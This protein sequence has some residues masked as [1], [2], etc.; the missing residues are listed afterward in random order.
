M[1]YKCIPM[2]EKC[3][4]SSSMKEDM[5]KCIVDPKKKFPWHV[6]FH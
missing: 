1:T 5:P 3:F 2:D 4:L 6:I